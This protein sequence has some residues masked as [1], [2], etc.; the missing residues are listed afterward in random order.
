MGAVMSENNSFIDDVFLLVR[1][2]M[3]NH[4]IETEKASNAA[5]SVTK[6]ISDN[7]AGCQVYVCTG[8]LKEAANRS[9]KIKAEFTGNNHRQLSR[10][11][12]LSLQRVYKILRV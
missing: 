10:K 12:N 7:W 8:K 11:Y 1:E 4:N 5:L 9:A 6:K 2:E 3:I